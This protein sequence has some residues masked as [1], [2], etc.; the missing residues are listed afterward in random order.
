MTPGSRRLTYKN[1]CNTTNGASE[2]I[3]GDVSFQLFH[4]W[5]SFK[6]ISSHILCLNI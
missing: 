3:L 4:L 1:L 6:T 5:Q 2:E